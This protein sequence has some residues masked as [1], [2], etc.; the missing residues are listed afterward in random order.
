MPRGS[1]RPSRSRRRPPPSWLSRSSRSRNLEIVGKE[2][3]LPPYPP[4]FDLLPAVLTF[5]P[6]PNIDTFSTQATGAILNALP[7][8][9]A[10]G[11]ANNTLNTGDNF[12][13]SAGDGTLNITEVASTGNPPFATGVTLNGYKTANITNQAVGTIGGFQGSITGLT[14]VNDNASVF[15]VQLGGFG[16]GLNTALTNVSINNYKGP[17]SAAGVLNADP[18]QFSTDGPAGTAAAPNL[19]YG[20]WAINVSDTWGGAGNAYLQLQQNGVGGPTALTLSGAGNI[21]IG[22]DKAGNWQK[23]TTIDATGETGN[24]V[25]TGAAAGNATNAIATATNPGGL[26]GSNAGLLDDGATG[27]FALT[28]FKFG[29]GVTTLDVSSATAA[30]VAALTTDPGANKQ[31]TNEII[32]ND[33]VASTTSATTFANIKGF[34]YVC[35]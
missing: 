2:P 13:D 34:D 27:T 10:S 4:L 23:L 32:V 31:T 29:T 35:L 16:Q 22:E 7:F 21:W 19:S 12:Q 3:N 26:W 6:T 20:T 24:V 5:N 11:L 33:A 9:Q 18:L 28:S 1:C 17:N 14:V 30:Q 15:G 25:V 8:V